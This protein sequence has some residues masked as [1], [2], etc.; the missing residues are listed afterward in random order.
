MRLLAIFDILWLAGRCLSVLC[1]YGFDRVLSDV[2]RR[3]ILKNT[4]SV[5]D[6]LFGW[7]FGGD[8]VCPFLYGLDV[9]LFGI[10]T[11]CWPEWFA[12]IC[13]GC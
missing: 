5:A 7:G 3:F 4:T 2:K 10:L 9:P 6:M 1:F 13:G 11:L 12:V 8:V